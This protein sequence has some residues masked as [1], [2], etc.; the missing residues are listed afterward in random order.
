[1][2]IEYAQKASVQSLDNKELIK[3]NP[4]QNFK[5]IGNAIIGYLL[6][7]NGGHAWMLM[8]HT[9]YIHHSPSRTTIQEG[10]ERWT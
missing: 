1:M 2:L 8:K 9:E 5:V 7:Q 4:G 10:R 6:R 3:A